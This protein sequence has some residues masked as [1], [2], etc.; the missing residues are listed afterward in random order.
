MAQFVSSASYDRYQ[1]ILKN[2]RILLAHANSYDTI[3]QDWILLEQKVNCEEIVK[4]N[5]PNKVFYFYLFIKE[6]TKNLV[7]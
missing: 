7:H 5:I 1:I 3:Y 4:S 6:K 2:S